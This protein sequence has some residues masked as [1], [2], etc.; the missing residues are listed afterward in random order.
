MAINVCTWVW[1]NSPH[2]GSNLLLLLAIADNAHDDG[3]GAY[4]SIKT[5]S[6]KTRMS[7]RT[8]HY[9]LKTLEQSGA[10]QTAFQ[11]GPNGVNVYTVQM[12]TEGGGA[13]FAPVQSLQG[14]K[15]NK[16]GVQNTT[17]RGAKFA[18]KPSKTVI[19]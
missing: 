17:E 8:V 4:P 2:K 10:I 16:G 18:P 6:Q 3:G 15:H 7:E 19:K 1:A 13:K 5:L 12:E 9:A 11:A 14:A